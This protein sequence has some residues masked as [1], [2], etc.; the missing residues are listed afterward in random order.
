MLHWHDGGSYSCS[1]SH[2]PQQYCAI[3]QE[4][5]SGGVLEIEFCFHG[6]NFVYIEPRELFARYL[7]QQNFLVAKYER[8]GSGES[9]T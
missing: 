9:G 3:G 8:S 7:S 1:G 6:Q 5:R 2:G 4:S